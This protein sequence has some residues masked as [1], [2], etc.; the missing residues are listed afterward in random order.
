MLD[1]EPLKKTR[2]G[3]HLAMSFE[4]CVELDFCCPDDEQ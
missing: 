1:S 3:T 2:L 4:E